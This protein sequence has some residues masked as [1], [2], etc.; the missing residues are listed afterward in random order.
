MIGPVSHR[1]HG[2]GRKCISPAVKAISPD[3]PWRAIAG[4]RDKFVHAYFRTNSQ[5]IWDVVTR[6]IDALEK[7]L[8][9]P[10]VRPPVAD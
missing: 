2:R 5:R 4:I 10:A 3:I 1:D 7:A 8:S 9:K 6:D